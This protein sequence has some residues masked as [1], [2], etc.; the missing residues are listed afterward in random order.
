MR[1]IAEPHFL[2]TALHDTKVHNYIFE[3]KNTNL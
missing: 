3:Y 1:G 2:S